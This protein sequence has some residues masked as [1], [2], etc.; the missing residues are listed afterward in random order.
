MNNTKTIS[1]SARLALLTMFS[2]LAAC[3]G[4]SDQEKA[5]DQAADGFFPLFNGIKCVF[6]TTDSGTPIQSDSD[7]ISL[8][9]NSPSP[10]N[11]VSEY[12]PNS[13]LNNAN[14]VFLNDTATAISGA[15]AV[16][17]DSAD[18]FIFTPIH[19]GDY[20][21]YLCADSCEIVLESNTLD[22]MILDQSQTTIA[23]TA[24]GLAGEKTLLTRLNA[25]VAYYIRVSALGTDENYRL[26]IAKSTD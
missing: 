3:G 7:M 23:A 22:L 14:P 17:D 16:K 15:L 13:S 10:A 19:T 26:A 24:L 20:R 6:G 21:V 25:G 11:Q 12:E 18:N 5:C 4:K 9:T 1:I 8:A 2:I